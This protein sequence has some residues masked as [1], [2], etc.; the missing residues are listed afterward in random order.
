MGWVDLVWNLGLIFRLVGNASFFNGLMMRFVRVGSYLSQN[1]GKPF[2]DSRLRFQLAKRGRSVLRL[3]FC[4]VLFCFFVFCYLFIYFCV[5][6]GRRVQRRKWEPRSI[7]FLFKIL[8]SRVGLY[9]LEFKGLEIDPQNRILK[10]SDPYLTRLGIRIRP[11]VFRSDMWVEFER[12]MDRLNFGKCFL[13]LCECENFIGNDWLKTVN[14]K[15]KC[16]L[17]P[18]LYNFYKFALDLLSLVF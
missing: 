1:R 15:R 16:V 9:W 17:E 14:I 7:I 13:D 10:L 8:G 18:K 2:L 11:R 6:K 12:L 4:F 5:W 3:V